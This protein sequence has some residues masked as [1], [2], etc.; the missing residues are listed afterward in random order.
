MKKIYFIS[1]LFLLEFTKIKSLQRPLNQG[2]EKCILSDFYIK[3]NIVITLNITEGNITLK[4]GVNSP[5][6]IINIYN[7]HNN[8]LVKQY[9]TS[10]LNA[11]F[12]FNVEKTGHYKTCIKCN[13]NQ[14]FDKN[15][16][17][18]F[19]LK[20]ESNLDVIHSNNE[21]AQVKDFEKVNQKLSFLSDK[22]EQIENMQLVAKNVENTFS[23]NQISSSRR[24]VW[25]SILQ[26][27]IIF[28][29]GSY[30]VYAI[31]DAFKNKTIKPSLINQENN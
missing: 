22:V 30:N 21:T 6:F 15:K 3:S 4:N 16:F 9:E 13:N 1:I 2:E 25:I 20:T 14:I 7:R 27:I 23:K 18:I 8:K 17:I 19:D 29:V 24:I 5:L 11:R 31:R 10:K 12:S 28:F 26:I